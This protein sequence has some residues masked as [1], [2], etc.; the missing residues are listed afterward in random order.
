MLSMPLLLFA[1]RDKTMSINDLY[2]IFGRKQ[3]SATGNTISNREN[4]GA[5]YITG[6]Q[7]V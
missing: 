4:L 1:N 3:T 5:P 7:L 6:M 2:P